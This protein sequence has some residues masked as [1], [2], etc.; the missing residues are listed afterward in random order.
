VALA[1]PIAATWPGRP[2]KSLMVVMTTSPACGPA[3]T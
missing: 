3:G 2:G 1:A